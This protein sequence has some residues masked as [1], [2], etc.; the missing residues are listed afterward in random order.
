[1]AFAALR[2][3]ALI[4]RSLFIKSDL[5]IKENKIIKCLEMQRFR[6]IF[7]FTY[8]CKYLVFLLRPILQILKWHNDISK[9]LILKIEKQL[10]LSNGRKLNY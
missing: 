3:L 4:L 5:N 9:N 10:C 2:F 8:K 1:M 7:L 6:I